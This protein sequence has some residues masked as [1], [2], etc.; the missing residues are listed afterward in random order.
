M[1]LVSIVISVSLRLIEKVWKIIPFL[2]E[3]FA[4]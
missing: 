1:L 2:P 3:R 4:G